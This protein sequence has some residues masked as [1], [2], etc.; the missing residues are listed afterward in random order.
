MI[1]CFRGCLNYVLRLLKSWFKELDEAVD[2]EIVASDRSN[3]IT[4]KV[5]NWTTWQVNKYSINTVIIWVT[6]E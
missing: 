4:L 2:V 1:L 6:T 5:Q 3:L